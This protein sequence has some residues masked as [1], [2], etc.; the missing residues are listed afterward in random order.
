MKKWVV[1]SMIVTMFL[2]VACAEAAPASAPAV[3]PNPVATSVPLTPTELLQKSFDRMKDV[4]T[5]KADLDAE[6]TTDGEVF[7][8]GADVAVAENGDLD[9]SAVVGQQDFQLG[10]GVKLIQPDVF[11]S[12]PLLGWHRIDGEAMAQDEGFSTEDFDLEMLRAFITSEIVP[13]HLVDATSLGTED[14]NGVETEHL[15][16]TADP[17]EVWRFVQDSGVLELMKAEFAPDEEHE[18]EGME[19]V[20]AELSRVNVSSSEL[21]IDS[22]GLV[23]KML[24]EVS[25]EEEFSATLAIELDDY[26]S[27]I[28]VEPPSQYTD[29]L[30]NGGFGGFEGMVPG[31]GSF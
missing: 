2:A 18:T 6:M 7:T 22:E 29:G 20:E 28:T 5:F 12:I 25:F 9:I 1:V 27:E 14:I 16:V 17:V 15:S 23:R 11:I 31:V 10:V 8:G 30:P 26:D 24:L 19:D 13:W 4:R 21:W 3:E